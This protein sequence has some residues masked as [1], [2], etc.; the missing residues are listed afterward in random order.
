MAALIEAEWTKKP[1]YQILLLG[2]QGSGK[3]WFLQELRHMLLRGPPP[4]TRL[5]P[6]V[7]QNV[8]EL[9]YERS[10]LHF[11]DLGGAPSMRSLWSQYEDDADVIAW[12]LDA[13]R[14]LADAPVE[15]ESAPTYRAAVCVTLCAMAR[16]ARARRQ[17]VVVLASQVD[18]PVAAQVPD[19]A[20]QIDHAL[21]DAWADTGGDGAP[22]WSVAA[23]S[24]STGYVHGH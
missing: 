23:V 6:T 13:P 15:G 4:S 14:F 18:A 2:L 24:A 10:V 12:V 1:K 22:P 19:V 16:E 8:L 5:P 17:G 21:H 11:W 3:T 9:P 7:G 20:A